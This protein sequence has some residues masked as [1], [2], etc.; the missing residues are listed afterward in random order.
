LVAPE[1]D[2]ASNTYEVVG[3]PVTGALHVS[4]TVD[5][6]T[7][8]VRFWGAPGAVAA[9]AA[10]AG[11]AVRAAEKH[12]AS[13]DPRKQVARSAVRGPNN[14]GACAGAVADCVLLPKDCDCEGVGL[15]T[16]PPPPR[17]ATAAEQAIAAVT[18]NANL[19]APPDRCIWS[20]LYINQ[21]VNRRILS[22]VD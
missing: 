20:F 13:P 2:P 18:T 4:V 21:Q 22:S 19:L 5:P 7:L 17:H 9:S 11:L 8:N 15:V 1:A 6:L 10:V 3:S 14:E 16:D 12:A